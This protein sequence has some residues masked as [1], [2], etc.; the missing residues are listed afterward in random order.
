MLLVNFPCRHRDHNR[1][2]LVVVL[3]YYFPYPSITATCIETNENVIIF[4]SMMIRKKPKYIFTL[5]ILIYLKQ[6]ADL[7]RYKPCVT[8]PQIPNS[9]A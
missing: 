2:S 3:K 7:H 6:T 1:R 5:T 4:M 9:I 8:V